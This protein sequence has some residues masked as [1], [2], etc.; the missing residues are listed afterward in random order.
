MDLSKS[1]DF[2]DPNKVDKKCNVI[3]T[4]SVGSYV[5]MFLVRHGITD[6]TVWDYDIVE[7]HNITNQMFYESQIGMPK[8]E[9]I[10]DICKAINDKVSITRRPKGWNGERLSGYVFLCV[11]SVELRKKILEENRFNKSIEAVFDFR[12][13]LLEGQCYFADWSKE[14]DKEDILA[15]MRFSDEEAKELAPV[16]ACG[17]E[18]SAAPVVVDTVIKGICNFTNYI[19]DKQT[20]KVIITNPYSFHLNAF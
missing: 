8:V 6:I 11:D 1:R 17:F 9:A 4:G 15:T 16:S 5:M 3:G 18:L 10:N 20:R 13:T 7:S 12:T 19:N 14:E 2:F